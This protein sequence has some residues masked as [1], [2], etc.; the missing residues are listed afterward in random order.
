MGSGF[1]LIIPFIQPLQE[2]VWDEAVTE[3][4]VNSNGTVYVE[5]NGE[6]AYVGK[7]LLD[8]KRLLYAMQR[9]ARDCGREL[10]EAQPYVD[11][12]LPDGSRI[13]ASLPPCSVG[14]PSLSIRKF[15]RNIF[16]LDRLCDLGAFSE[17]I[18]AFLQSAVN[19]QANILISGRTGCGKTSLAN[20]L[21]NELDPHKERIVVLE[22]SAEMQ[23]DSENVQRFQC[24]DVAGLPSITMRDLVK[25]SLR[26]R[27]DRLI[28]GETRGAE[29]MDLLDAL[30][31]G[32]GGSMTT[33]HANTAK[34]A[35]TKLSNL[36]LR[37]AADIPHYA[38]QAQIADVLHYV[39]QMERHGEK[40]RIAEIQQVKEYD[41]E[42]RGFI[43]EEIYAA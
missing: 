25:L 22:E 19:D 20:S 3:I 23:I 28:V 21:L 35:L 13:A 5:K 2:Y 29:A 15:S 43:L 39:I 31:S 12:R 24:R 32:H 42:K 37:A 38:I 16:S 8:P 7:N 26:Y 36:A 9:I 34:S 41:V 10:D 17:S 33:I 4:C 11:A 14:G 1:A 40:R 27:P 6:L 30:N 18:K